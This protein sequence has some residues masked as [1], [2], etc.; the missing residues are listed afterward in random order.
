MYILD[1]D[2]CAPNPCEN[3]ATCED[4]INQATCQCVDGWTGNT[5]E[6]GKG[7]RIFEINLICFNL[8]WFNLDIITQALFILFHLILSSY[9]KLHATF[10]F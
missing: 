10:T 3:G 2:D 8:I 5:C 7:L 6:T 4:G 1:I 9:E